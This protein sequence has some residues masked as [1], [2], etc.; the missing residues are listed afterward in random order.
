MDHA[1]QEMFGMEAEGR[2][3]SAPCVLALRS[4]DTL[5]TQLS[6]TRMSRKVFRRCVCTRNSPRRN[7]SS[8]CSAS[9]REAKLQVQSSG[10]PSL[11]DNGQRQLRDAP[12]LTCTPLLA[13][14]LCKP[15]LRADL[16]SGCQ[17]A[18]PRAQ[19][20]REL[21]IG[22]VWIPE[23]KKWLAREFVAEPAVLEMLLIPAAVVQ[24]ANAAWHLECPEW[25]AFHIATPGALLA[26]ELAFTAVDSAYRGI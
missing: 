5:G 12:S 10:H 17:T 18:F 14:L 9:H 19:R 13:G 24:G 21:V 4:S 8:L 1:S 16:R 22:A 6:L 2:D 25:L 20:C 3:H 15:L 7:V 23:I 26:E 11:P